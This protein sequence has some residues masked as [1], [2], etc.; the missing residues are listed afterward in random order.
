ML[1]G[2]CVC[3]GGGGIGGGGG[4]VFKCAGLCVSIKLVYYCQACPLGLC[5]SEYCMRGWVQTGY[6][7]VCDSTRF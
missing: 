6:V 1:T 5:F 4:G 2:L 3:V 7:W